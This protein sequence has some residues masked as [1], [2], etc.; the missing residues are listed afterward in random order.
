MAQYHLILSL[1]T[2]TLSTN[3]PEPPGPPLIILY[4]IIYLFS[5]VLYIGT[6]TVFIIFTLLQ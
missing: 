1:I 4:Y 6:C 2:G 3:P 5:L